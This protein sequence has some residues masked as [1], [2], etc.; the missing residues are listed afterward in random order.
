MDLS[1]E[2]F[3]TLSKFIYQKS[4]LKFDLR[5]HYFISKRIQKRMVELRMKSI[6]EYIRFLRFTDFDKREFSKLISLLTTNESYFFRDFGQLQSFAEYC[7]PEIVTQKAEKGDKTLRIWSA[8]CSSGEEAYTIAIILHEILNNIEDWKIEIIA[9][10][11]DT[12]ILTKAKIAEYTERSVKEVPDEYIDRYFIQRKGDYLVKTE[13]KSMVDFVEQNLND[14]MAVRR[15]KNFDFV[16]C[17]NVLIYF[18]EI[19]RKRTVDNFYL[20][21]NTGGYIFLGSSESIGRV[22][23]AFVLKRRGDYLVYKKE[24]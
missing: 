20:S 15:M 7:L 3:E 23:N 5:K 16:F 18:D 13:I 6:N 12:N 8:G 10:D 17:R 1:L 19:S 21:L 9:S 24:D 2:Q 4:G 14:Q 22:S 11:I